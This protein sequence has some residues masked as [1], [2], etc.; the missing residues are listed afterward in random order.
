[1]F[2]PPPQCPAVVVPVQV[3]DGSHTPVSPSEHVPYVQHCQPLAHISFSPSPDSEPAYL[4]IRPPFAEPRRT[5]PAHPPTIRRRNTLSHKPAVLQP[6]LVDRT[7]VVLANRL[8][9]LLGHATLDVR[10]TAAFSSDRDAGVRRTAGG[11]HAG[12]C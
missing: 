7:Y 10:G 12:A 9:V 3:D 11:G 4:N 2:F 5:R 8:R 1:M 6:S